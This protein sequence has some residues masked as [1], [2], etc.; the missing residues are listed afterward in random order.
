V[1]A[2]VSVALLTEAL[3]CIWSVFRQCFDVDWRL[4]Q[5]YIDCGAS[6]QGYELQGGDSKAD[7]QEVTRRF[8]IHCTDKRPGE[9]QAAQAAFPVAWPGTDGIYHLG[10][11]SQARG[12][13]AGGAFR[14]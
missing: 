14:S 7:Q 4:E 8:S 10:Y 6:S 2:R 5:P 3:P 1:L 11:T 12:R 13:A 9:L